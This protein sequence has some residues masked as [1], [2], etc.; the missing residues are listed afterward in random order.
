MPVAGARGVYY[1]TKEHPD[2]NGHSPQT[3]VLVDRRRRDEDDDHR[4][5]PLLEKQS[6]RSSSQCRRREMQ[7][8]VSTD[9]TGLFLFNLEER[10]DGAEVVLVLGEGHVL[11]RTGAVGQRGVVGAEEDGDG[12]D[13]AGDAG[14]GAAGDPR[15]PA[16]VVAAVAAQHDVGGAGV[17]VGE[18]RAPTALPERL[19]RDGVPE[20]HDGRPHLSRCS[21]SSARSWIGGPSQSSWHLRPYIDGRMHAGESATT[22]LCRCR[23]R[24]RGGRFGV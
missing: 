8:C 7:V 21:S 9:R 5:P 20:Q 19:L 12:R 15:R 11:E 23:H 4:R 17:V 6:N 22:R 2:R 16:R 24:L 1:D 3:P 18:R 14:H 13:R 10:E